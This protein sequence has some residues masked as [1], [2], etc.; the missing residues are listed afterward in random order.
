MTFRFHPEADEDLIESARY[1][2]RQSEGLGDEFLA[3][4]ED[5]LRRINL[6]PK[7]SP[8]DSKRIRRRLVEGFPYSVVYELENGSVIIFAIAH[9]S[10]RPG[11]WSGRLI[12]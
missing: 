10:R 6:F 7:A 9:H 12:N 2:E 4:V 11:Y 1:Y 5:T 3:A 8:A